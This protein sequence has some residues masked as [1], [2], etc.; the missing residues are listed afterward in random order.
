MCACQSSIAQNAPAKTRAAKPSV[1]KSQAAPAYAAEGN[2][3]TINLD[4][5]GTSFT[6]EFFEKGFAKPPAEDYRMVS[7]FASFKTAEGCNSWF[8]KSAIFILD[9]ISTITV[10]GP[11]QC[12]LPAPNR[13]LAIWLLEQ[14]SQA[15]IVKVQLDDGLYDI[16]PQQLSA[17]REFVDTRLPTSD[18]RKAHAPYE[19]GPASQSMAYDA[20]SIYTAIHAH[21]SSA[22]S[23][24]QSGTFR[25][26]RRGARLDFMI[27]ATE[28]NFHEGD[29]YEFAWSDLQL[30]LFDVQCESCVKQTKESSVT[31]YKGTTEVSMT[32]PIS[33]W[34]S[35]NLSQEGRDA[36]RAL[37]FL[38]YQN[39]YLNQ[40][41]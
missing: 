22:L 3:F 36:A 2:N 12:P 6:F 24:R 35:T 17:L 10:P 7:V 40:R 14:I 21:F 38:W 5:H 29:E 27:D 30:S 39:I 37:A 19:L 23:G 34:G 32:S 1:A 33:L 18:W 26:D 28:N 8:G 4:Q 9:E 20:V 16:T 25:S 31:G 41:Y 13:V 11:A 15:Q